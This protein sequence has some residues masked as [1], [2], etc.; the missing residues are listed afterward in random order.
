MA[1]QIFSPPAIT[2]D[3]RPDGTVLLSSKTPLGSFPSSVLHSFREGS[4]R[5]PD[6]VLVAE[7]VS[8]DWSTCSWGQARARVDRIAQ[9]LIDRD[10]AGR[11]VLFLSHNSV[12]YLLMALAAYT[13]GSP[14]VPVSPA[15]S[16][17]STDYSKLRHI[18]E[19][20]DP[21]AVFAED[22]TYLDAL[23]AIGEQRVL[24]TATPDTSDVTT[25]VEALERD[26]T[27][28][29]DTAAAAVDGQT[30][31]KIIFT[32]GS[33]GRP[34]GVVNTHEMLAAN[35]QQLRQTWP[36]LAD[37]PPVLLDWLPWCHTF[38]GNL[39]INNVLVNGGSMWIDDGR[40]TAELIGRT[41][42]NLATVQPTLHFNVPAGYA[43]L[44]PYLERHPDAARLFFA[45]L[46]IAFFGSAALPQQLW[47]RYEALA[48]QYGSSAGLTTAWGMTE[49]APVATSAHFPITRSDC[50]GVPVPGMELKLVPSGSKYELLV[51]GPN[52]TKGYY[53]RP[54]LVAECFDEEGFLRSGDLCSPVDPSDPNKGL[55][56]G[57]RIA[58]NFKLS[59][60]TFVTVGTLR[61]KLLSAC[62]GILQDAVICGH[63]T[64]F[65]SA[66]VWLHPDHAHRVDETGMPEDS[67]RQDLANALARLAA[68]GGGSSHR[69]ERL[70]VQVVPPA[71][72]AGEITDKSYINQRVVREGRA[73]QVA[74]LTAAGASARTICRTR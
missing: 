39:N 52:V 38:G 53:N 40:P 30:V 61:P 16:L 8:D 70:L 66:L 54:D 4:V 68:E 43:V 24:V 36:F 57:G 1:L 67:L 44:L 5:H 25:P 64:D 72:D 42:E 29:V 34:K 69:V 14:I 2:A 74:E 51:R 35:Q 3:Q 21:A 41:I 45:Q 37:E 9:G 71:L 48:A 26:A 62:S 46:R 23:R 10:V 49:T 6:R 47:E 7:R 18:L 56:Y 11:P 55:L 58:E 17:Q 63:D 27:A 20:C 60:G 65:V 33:T 50:I 22:N 59:T 13:V 73:D 15:Y 32:S 31:A 19:V 12:S 28:A